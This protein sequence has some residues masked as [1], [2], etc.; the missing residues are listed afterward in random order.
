MGLNAFVVVR[1]T[2]VDL[3]SVIFIL[4][5]VLRICEDVVWTAGGCLLSLIFCVDGMSLGQLLGS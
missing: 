1:L 3:R 5:L 4:L 2:F